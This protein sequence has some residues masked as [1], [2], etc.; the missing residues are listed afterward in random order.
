M[1]AVVFDEELVVEDAEKAGTIIHEILSQVL[2]RVTRI[3]IEKGKM[4]L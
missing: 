1:K 2:P 4:T 3:Y